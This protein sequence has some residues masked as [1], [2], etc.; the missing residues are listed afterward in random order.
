MLH[1]DGICAIMDGS[2]FVYLEHVMNWVVFSYSL[3]SKSSSPRV[4]TWRQL[5]RIGAISIAGGAYVLPAREGCVEAFQWLAQK[6]RQAG[7]EAVVMHVEHLDVADQQIIGLFRQARQ[8]DYAEIETEAAQ[9][10]E[11]TQRQEALDLDP[12]LGTLDKLQRRH[13][14]VARI[15]YFGCPEGVSLAARLARIRRALFSEMASSVEI[16]PAEVEAYRGRRWVTRPHPHV[17][18]LACTWLIRRYIDPDAVIRYA[19]EAVPDE[20][21]FDMGDSEFSHRGDLCTF[22]V[23]LAAFGL[24]RPA[25]RAVAEVVHEVDLHDGRFMRPE[26]SGVDALLRGWQLLV[27]SDEEM[28]ACGLALFD[29]LHA[30]FADD[31]LAGG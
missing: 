13:A 30:F 9:L 2:E 16:L 17:D 5:Q 15:D 26:M 1:P 19:L 11:A 3:P 8:K 18:R 6:V 27:L 7:G 24:D 20:I 14:D 23:M 10:E 21:A 22:E 25:L 4:S 12:I 31:T 28:E 29:G